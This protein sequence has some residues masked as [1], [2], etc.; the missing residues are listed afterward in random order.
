MPEDVVR[1]TICIWL[2]NSV[3]LLS[4]YYEVDVVSK[5]I[6]SMETNS[7]LYNARLS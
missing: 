4:L 5:L 1:M 6:V 3:C 2:L 7:H